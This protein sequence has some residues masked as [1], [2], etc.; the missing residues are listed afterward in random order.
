[1]GWLTA[2]LTLALSACSGAPTAFN[3]GPSGTFSLRV[4]HELALRV[5]SI[6]PGEY[7]APPQISSTAIRFVSSTLV[8]PAVPAGETQL[9][10]FKGVRSGSAI[11]TFQHTNISAAIVDTV[12]VY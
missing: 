9:F 11:I 6:G 12:A 4:G 7:T 1:M 2:A 8:G 10:R 3:A 5:Q